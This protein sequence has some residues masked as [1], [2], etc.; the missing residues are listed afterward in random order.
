MDAVLHDDSSVE[1]SEPPK[2]Q[3]KRQRSSR[4]QSEPERKRPKQ[5]TSKRHRP[6]PSYQIITPG[7][8]F[9]CVMVPPTSFKSKG[10][11]RA[12]EARSSDPPEPSGDEQDNSEDE[13]QDQAGREH[14]DPDEED[15]RVRELRRGRSFKGR[16][17]TYK[18]RRSHSRRSEVSASSENV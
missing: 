13:L 1:A 15:G 12:T 2:S 5:R 17:R 6:V 14:V 11:A 4:A 16:L 9:D 18:S 3:G 7:L 8:Q 10:K